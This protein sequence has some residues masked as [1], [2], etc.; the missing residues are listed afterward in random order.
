MR[1]RFVESAFDRFESRPGMLPQILSVLP[2]DKST[3]S[4]RVAARPM[5][6]LRNRMD[7]Q[8]LSNEIDIKSVSSLFVYFLPPRSLGPCEL[9]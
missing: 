4:I 9:V 7:I 6:G 8:S 3:T 5:H 2:S 1:R